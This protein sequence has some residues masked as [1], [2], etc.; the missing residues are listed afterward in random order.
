MAG[1]QSTTW[2]DL[3]PPHPAA[4]LFPV[5]PEDELR[6]HRRDL[7]N[8]PTAHAG[9]HLWSELRTPVPPCVSCMSM[10]QQNLCLV[11]PF[12]QVGDYQGNCD[13]PLSRAIAGPGIENGGGSGCSPPA[14]C[15]DY[16]VRRPC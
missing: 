10:F 14:D 6:A 5:L 13:Q 1:R 8:S 15:Q 12:G 4:D 7:F 3:W 2:R 11:G 16:L 9:S